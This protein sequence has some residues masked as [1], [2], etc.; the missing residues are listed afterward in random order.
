MTR[1]KRSGQAGKRYPGVSAATNP[2]AKAIARANAS[3]Q[4]TN[5]ASMDDALRYYQRGEL[6]ASELALAN[7]LKARPDCPSGANLKAIILARTGRY[8][9]AESVLKGLVASQPKFVD[10]HTNLGFLL[11]QR[12]RFDEAERS[13]RQA[14]ALSPQHADAWLNLGLVLNTLKR[15]DEAEA[16][17]RRTLELAPGSAQA[18]F[19]LAKMAQDRFDFAAAHAGYRRALQLDPKFHDAWANLIFTQHY[20]D[21]HDPAQICRESRKLAALSGQGVVPHRHAP[22]SPMNGRPL[23]IG[24]VSGDLRDHPV[25]YFLEHLIQASDLQR[26]NFYAY[27]TSRTED[28]L[29]ASIK[30]YF[31]AWQVVDAVNDPGLAQA[32]LADKIDILVDLAGYSAGN[33]LSVFAYRPAPIQVSW[34]G[35][36]ATTGLPA[37][38]YVLADP[39][40]VP[41]GEEAFFSEKVW[42]LPH[43][44]FCFSPP[45]NAPL[46]TPLPALA[47]QPF[48]FACYQN[49]SKVN[50]K[51]L[52][53]WSKI[54][55]GSPQARLKIQAVQLAD[56]A[57]RSGFEA[58]LRGAGIDPSR[59]VLAAAVPRSDYLD[60][61]RGVDL[62]LDTFPY[63]GGTTTVEALWMGVPTLTL[64]TPGMLGRQGSGI[65]ATQGL[66]EFICADAER[67]VAE[68]IA[69]A[70]PERWARL[71]LL[72]QGLRERMAV[73]PLVDARGFARDLEH[74]FYAM[75]AQ[76]IAAA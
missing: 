62:L 11:Q 1:S 39:Y 41:I 42:R 53:L 59:V 60:S 14:L 63:P 18:H 26:L 16:A 24:F 76:G 61:Y 32:I 13:L 36:F 58:R 70:Q 66:D 31:A 55:K 54:L 34:L 67:Y 12:Q 71:A 19:N 69:W 7:Y 29:T 52:A 28:A 17:Y 72:R 57:D 27:S 47:G 30:P 48:T 4:I 43:S 23:R 38:D 10:G 25:G 49:L 50:G 6:A 21:E 65:L 8:D 2:I 9:E 3:G 20:L 40:C 64:S 56:P 15:H 75:H 33:R 74:A 68:A 51:V 5:P 44:R 73:S 37:M 35:Y 45:A 22:L 46:G